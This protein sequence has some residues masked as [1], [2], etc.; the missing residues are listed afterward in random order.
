[1]KISNAFTDEQFKH[2]KR[3]IDGMDGESIKQ[4]LDSKEVSEHLISLGIYPGYMYYVLEHTT[5]GWV[6]RLDK[7]R[8]TELMIIVEARNG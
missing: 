8:D 3:L 1:M 7:V 2:L 5:N 6:E 4:Y